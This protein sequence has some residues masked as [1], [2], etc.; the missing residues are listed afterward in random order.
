[1]NYFLSVLMPKSVY[2]GQKLINEVIMNTTAKTP[3]IIDHVPEITFVKY[4]TAIITATA[5][6]TDLSIV[7]MFFFMIIF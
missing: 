1:M 4:K 7:P 3:S 2:K 5:I 6:R